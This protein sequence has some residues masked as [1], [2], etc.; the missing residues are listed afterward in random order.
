MLKC[1]FIFPWYLGIYKC[2]HITTRI[3]LTLDLSSTIFPVVSQLFLKFLPHCTSSPTTFMFVKVA[4]LAT[5]VSTPLH[6]VPILYLAKNKYVSQ[7]YLQKFLQLEK[8]SWEETRLPIATGKCQ[9]SLQHRPV[10]PNYVYPSK[11][12]QKAM[13]FLKTIHDSPA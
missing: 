3:I 9:F 10:T 2:S 12:K 8:W 7:I 13:V 11:N 6:R 4:F 1:Q 5:H